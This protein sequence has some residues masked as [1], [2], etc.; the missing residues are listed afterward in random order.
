ME[1][2]MINVD[3][4]STVIQIT[5]GEKGVEARQPAWSPDGLQIA[6][7]VKRF[8]VYQIWL[9]NA[10]GT[11][12][13][14]IVRSGVAFSDYLPTWS[15]DGELIL[16]TQRCATKFCLPYLMSISAKDRSKEQGSFLDFNVISIS[17]VEYS[18]D[19]FHLVYEG[20]D[21]AENKDVYYMTAA[22]ANSVRIT[23]EDGL[24]FDPTWRPSGN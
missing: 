23:T 9:M 4:L 17:D 14:Q 11:E 21:K 20:E 5:N 19:G 18:P 1:I 8:G 15:P 7:E 2:F 16:F 3:N 6:Y 24:D 12:Q 10:D 13:K 22:G